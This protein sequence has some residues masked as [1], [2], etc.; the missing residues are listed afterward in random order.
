MVIPSTTNGWP[1]TSIGDDAFADCLSLTS[2]TIPSSVTS[3]GS[4]SFW[5]CSSLAS[6]TIPNSVTNIGSQA[7]LFCR[8]LTN[9][10]VAAND[11]AY[12]SV[13]GVLF[14]V[15]QANLIQ[16]PSGLGGSYAIPNSA[17]NIGGEAFFEC[18][19]LTNVTIPSSV[20]S[21]GD[22]AFVVCASLT[23]VTIPKQ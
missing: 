9:I 18:Y 7:F 4:A 20:T 11:P 6:V 12:S 1:V 5:D 2:V 8:S 21:I 22:Y 14:D 15:G 23:G 17:T 13:G 3:I 10:T 16:F 19:S